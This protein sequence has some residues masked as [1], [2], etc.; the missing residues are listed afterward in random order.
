MA[1]GS[2]SLLKNTLVVAVQHKQLILSSDLHM[3]QQLWS[4]WNTPEMLLND[5]RR[6]M[7]SVPESS[8]DTD[9]HWWMNTWITLKKHFLLSGLTEQT[10]RPVLPSARFQLEAHNFYLTPPFGVLRVS[11]LLFFQSFESR[12][13]L[14]F[15]SLHFF[16]EKA[17]CRVY[18]EVHFLPFGV[19]FFSVC[20]LC[21]SEYL[22]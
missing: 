18:C 13:Q 3:F 6:V 20:L 5:S 2:P 15:R 14:C 1:R 21:V 7:H 17:V 12:S 9:F 10:K 4:R 16:A 22:P 8:L 11:A 19:L